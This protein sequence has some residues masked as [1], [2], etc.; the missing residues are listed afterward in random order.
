MICGFPIPPYPTQLSLISSKYDLREKRKLKG[1][2]QDPCPPKRNNTP[3]KQLRLKIGNW[4]KMCWCF[5]FRFPSNQNRIPT[6]S[7]PR[8][9]AAPGPP[10]PRHAAAPQG[11]VCSPST[12]PDMTILGTK[13]SYPKRERSRQCSDAQRESQVWRT[14]C[15]RR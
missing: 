6:P 13:T 12:P 11:E 7:T 15:R 3:N 1:Y 8:P 2:P 10:L 14:Y 4:T 9:P 5:F